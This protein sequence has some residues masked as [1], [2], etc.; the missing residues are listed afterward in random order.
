MKDIAKDLGLSVVTISKVLRN[1]ADISEET[2]ERVL[3]R[4]EELNY[5]PNLAARALVTGRTHTVGLLVPDLVHPFF[6]EIA[7]GLGRALRAKD[8]GLFIASSEEDPELESEEIEQMLSRRVDVLVI[9]S[10]HRSVK[11]FQRVQEKGI[12]FVLLDRTVAGLPANFVGIDDE[13]AGRLATEHLIAAGCKRIAHIRGPE[14]STA[15]GRLAGYRTA[16]REHK[17]QIGPEYVAADQCDDEHGDLRGYSAMRKLLTV[18][19]LPDA[20][21]CYNDPTAMGA[22]RAIFEAGLRVPADIAVI[23]SGNFRYADL[24]Q[25]PLSSID[26]RSIEMGAAV[27]ELALSLINSKK[28]LPPR[29][30][31]ME[32]RVIARASTAR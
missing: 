18:E 15:L 27:G 21:F 6:G 10:S 17:L 4:M 31:L 16:L 30:V 22:L 11:S 2:R 14:V 12:P 1:H 29:T 26:Q 5:R 28:P 13:V 9:A 19:P 25:V 20:V 7:K 3:K 32:P 8:Y 24:L 23:G